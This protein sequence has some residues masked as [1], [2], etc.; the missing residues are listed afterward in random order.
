MT[1]AESLPVHG[2]GRLSAYVYTRFYFFL[3]RISLFALLSPLRCS[4]MNLVVERTLTFNAYF[5]ADH[6]DY[7][8][9]PGT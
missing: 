4:I 8:T 1:Y 2:T 7:R 3:P 9:D 6:R 5:G